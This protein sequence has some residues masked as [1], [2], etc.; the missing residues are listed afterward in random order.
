MKFLSKPDINSPLVVWKLYISVLFK[1]IIIDYTEKHSH[2]TKTPTTP[3]PQQHEN[4]PDNL[5]GFD[6]TEGLSRVA[7]N[8]ELYKKLLLSFYQD[9]KEKAQQIKQALQANDFNTARHLAHSVKGVSGNISA[10]RLFAAARSL[11][12]QLNQESRKNLPELL[13]QFTAAMDE[14]MDSLAFLAR[15]KSS[16]VTPPPDNSPI[17]RDAVAGSIKELA[18]LL[19]EFNMDAEQSF[20]NLKNQLSQQQYKQSMQQLE[21]AISNLEFDSATEILTALADTLNIKLC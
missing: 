8:H 1:Y 5:S 14:V 12:L 9:N 3:M 6:L 7:G 16:E 19:D 4:F 15:I 13:D 20:Q 21:V 10:K 18:A 11:E 2:T 17:N